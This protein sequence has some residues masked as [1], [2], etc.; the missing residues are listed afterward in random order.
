MVV[1]NFRLFITC[2][3]GFLDIIYEVFNLWFRNSVKI[4]VSN[5]VSRDSLVGTIRCW[6]D[7]TISVTSCR[8]WV[9]VRI[10]WLLLGIA[11]FTRCWKT[12]DLV[13]CV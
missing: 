4:L 7:Y 6:A 12:M 8:C 9:N 13:D 11:D 2:S 3:L 10:T 5:T 1:C